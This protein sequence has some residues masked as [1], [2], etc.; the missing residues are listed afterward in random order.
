MLLHS[1]DA[2][3][4]TGTAYAVSHSR[5]DVRYCLTEDLAWGVQEAWRAVKAGRRT[6][7]GGSAPP[8]SRATRYALCDIYAISMRKQRGTRYAVRAVRFPD[9]L[10][11]VRYL[12]T[13]AIRTLLCR[14]RYTDTLA[15][16]YAMSGTWVRLQCGTCYAIS[17][18]AMCWLEL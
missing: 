3:C 4:G 8:R 1:G 6:K 14:V 17:G 2:T 13:L 18:T 12:D 16:T 7:R 10:C 5:C 15:V 11:H 9:L